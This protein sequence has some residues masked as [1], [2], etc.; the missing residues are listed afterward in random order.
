MMRV[1]MGYDSH[2]FAAG[3]PLVLGGVTI[4][5]DR[6]LLGHSDADALTHA[7]I[8]AVLGAAAAG[9][10]GSHFPDTDPAW[11]R[12][13]SMELLRIAHAAAAREGWRVCQVDATVILEAPKLQPWIRDMAARLSDA[14]GL[15]AGQVSVKAKTNEGMGFVG[16]GEGV[17][18]LAVALLC[19]RDSRE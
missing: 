6:G 16:R 11:R 1:G 9:D 15:P 8:D 5:S 14:L 4:P 17:A 18:A 12:A 13:D 10:I 19:G 3:R 7:V 2:R